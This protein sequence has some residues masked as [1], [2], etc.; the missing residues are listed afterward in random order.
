MRFGIPPS[1][2]PPAFSSM[3]IHSG[4][5]CASCALWVGIQRGVRTRPFSLGT[6]SLGWEDRLNIKTPPQGSC[7]S[8]WSHGTQDDVAGTDCAN[9]GLRGH[10][11]Q[12]GIPGHGLLT[13]TCRALA[14]ALTSGVCLRKQ[15][16]LSGL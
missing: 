15:P 7:R 2:L 9:R 11:M 1:L 16:K 6:H 14:G 10:S 8:G 5:L 4:S 3:N 12:P 13:L